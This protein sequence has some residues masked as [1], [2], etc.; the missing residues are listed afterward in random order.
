MMQKWEGWWVADGGC[1]GGIGIN[2]LSSI[3]VVLCAMYFENVWSA[4]LLPSLFLIIILF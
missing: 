2:L 1:W 4:D 3:H